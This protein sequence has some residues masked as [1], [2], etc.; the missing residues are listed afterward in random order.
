MISSNHVINP[1]IYKKVPFD[2]LKDITPIS[3]IGTVPRPAPRDG[4]LRRA[5]AR[6]VGAQAMGDAVAAA[7][8]RFRK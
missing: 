5:E 6:K 1:S 8:S 7:L 2:S 4:A 3:V